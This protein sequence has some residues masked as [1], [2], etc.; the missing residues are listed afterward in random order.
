MA[1]A[2]RFFLLFSFAVLSF[3]KRSS[4]AHNFG[5][6]LLPSPNTTATGSEWSMGGATWYGSPNGAGSDG[7]A[8]GYGRGVEEPPFSSM[9][10]AGGPSLFE[11]GKGCGA[12]Y[13]IKCTGNKAC[14]GEPVTVVITD[15]C[16]G[17]PCLAESAHFDMSGSAFG[18]M[19]LPGQAEKLRS[20]GLLAVQYIR[21]ECM[22]PGQN[23]VFQV[24]PGSNPN[25]L[26]VLIEYED[27]DG[28]LGDVQL[29]QGQG[30]N[31]WLPMKQS[32]GAVWKIDS[33]SVLQAPFSF[34]LT[35][36][37]SG[38]ILVAADVIPTGWQ[39]GATY[40]SFVN[41]EG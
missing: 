12:C 34:R 13:Q 39:P 26:A 31:S 1:S 38:K 9:I 21:T 4:F 2:S 41:F 28:D 19:A 8:C 36:L 14:S 40:R 22:Y 37:S 23:V 17:G 24:D 25:Y 20:A 3:D 10:S 15:E 7:G 11:S 33:A 5:R 16:P 18:A 35:S 32:W 29:S 27:G 30:S 6:K